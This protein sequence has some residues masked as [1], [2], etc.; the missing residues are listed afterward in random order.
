M[1]TNSLFILLTLVGGLLVSGFGQSALAADPPVD[2]LSGLRSALGAPDAVKAKGIKAWDDN[3]C[4]TDPTKPA[5]D[6]AR[7]MMG[8]QQDH[9]SVTCD[10]AKTKLGTTKFPSGYN[11]KVAKAC[12]DDDGD[13][14]ILALGSDPDDGEE[15]VSGRTKNACSNF[16]NTSCKARNGGALSDAKSE[17][18]SA[19]ERS[20]TAQ[21][22]VG[23]VEEEMAK[24]DQDLKDDQERLTNEV[25]EA[26]QRLEQQNES[27]KND[28]EDGL[29]KAGEDMQKVK[30]EVDKA[31]ADFDKAYV[32]MRAQFRQADTENLM[33]IDGVESECRKQADG[34]RNEIA[35]KLEAIIRNEY[36]KPRVHDTQS[37]A[38]SKKRV[39]KNTKKKIQAAYDETYARCMK[40]S[41][42]KLEAIEKNKKNQIALLEDQAALI[43]NNRGKLYE[44]LIQRSQASE[45][46]KQKIQDRAKQASE[47]YSKE[48]E[49]TISKKQRENQTVINKYQSNMQVKSKK[50]QQ[51]Y[52]KQSNYDMELS[53]AGTRYN[54]AQTYGSLSSS[55]ADHS[56]DRIQK[57]ADQLD[58]YRVACDT[59]KIACGSDSDKM[60]REEINKKT[61]PDYEPTKATD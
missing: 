6:S 2:P 55:E 1:R 12:L 34:Q 60:C 7:Q 59:T 19:R 45:Q 49:S 61:D 53:A 46:Q 11:Y 15:E 58:E 4:D 17:R 33:A 38:G 41:A 40:S 47:R 56:L 35:L 50:L 39:Q 57:S 28:V 29:A 30:E 9:K 23:T 16:Y 10:A 42:K 22:N 48:F 3:K 54:C 5:C 32:Q 24:L 26:S 8:L 31:F 20:E 36:S 37:L 13:S 14:G 21:E 52:Q 43:E 51:A 18:D 27:L 25:E 44:Q